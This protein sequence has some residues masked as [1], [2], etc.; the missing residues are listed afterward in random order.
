MKH[1]SW[2]I[3]TSVLIGA[4]LPQRPHHDRCRIMLSRGRGMVTCTQVMREFL[5]VATRP[6]NVNGLGLTLSEARE[7]LHALESLAP[8]LPEQRP[9]WPAFTI[10][11]ERY[12]VAGKRLHDLHLAATAMAHDLHGVIT[13]NTA[14]FAPWASS[15]ACAHPDA[16]P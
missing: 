5:A 6:F 1:P 7:E 14:D 11:L 16:T 8:V 15:V 12:P 9:I 10:L 3:D 2:L 4:Y 13:L